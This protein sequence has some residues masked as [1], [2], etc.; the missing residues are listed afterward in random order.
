MLILLFFIDSNNRNNIIIV[1]TIKLNK[2]KF[3]IGITITNNGNILF[4]KFIT[5]NNNSIAT[6]KNKIN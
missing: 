5:K 1:I 3:S 6:N 2:L 4:L